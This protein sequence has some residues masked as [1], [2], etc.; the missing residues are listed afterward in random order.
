LR[1]LVNL[2]LGLYSLLLFMLVRFF[3]FSPR[4]FF[5]FS[6]FDWFLPV[7]H[8][9]SAMIQ[10]PNSKETP[11]GVSLCPASIVDKAKSNELSASEIDSPIPNPRLSTRAV[12]RIFCLSWYSRCPGVLFRRFS[13]FVARM[14]AACSKYVPLPDFHLPVLINPLSFAPA[15]FE[16]L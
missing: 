15:A 7:H 8:D 2:C 10:I 12:I 14:M 9:S 16:S 5:L 3:V 4:V 11:F 6:D 1:A 13:V